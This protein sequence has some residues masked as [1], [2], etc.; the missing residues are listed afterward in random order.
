MRILITGASGFIGGAVARAL[1]E[2]GHD[3]VLAV[4]SPETVRAAFPTAHV[5]ACDFSAWLDPADWTDALAGVDVVI[6][7]VGI[8]QQSG[9]QRFEALH[10]R[11]PVALFRAARDAKVRHVIQISALGADEGAVSCYHRTKKAADDAL[12]AL[13]LDGVILRPSL[14][15]GA[16]AGSAAL[17]RAL[18][19]LPLTPLV[20]EGRQLVQPILIDDL[21]RAV[22]IEV[23]SRAAGCPVIDAVGPEPI[24]FR[25]LLALLCDRFGLGR[26]R[27][28]SVPPA[29]AM[30]LA[31]LAPLFGSGPVTAETVAMLQRG[32]AAAVEPFVMRY[33]F[34]PQRLD[35][36]FAERP[37]SRAERREARLYFAGPALRLGIALLWIWTGLVSLFLFPTSES[38][39]L[40]ERVGL[41]GAAGP[42]ALHA[43]ALL[44][45]GI[46]MAVLTGIKPRAVGLLQ[47][48]VVLAYSGIITVALPEF[49]LHP[50]GPLAKNVPL[51]AAIFVL[52]ALEDGR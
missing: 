15:Y 3:L 8:I 39:D 1:R 4:R 9:L 16:D 37:A 18:A 6:N 42:F 43:A 23:E 38:L 41:T 46:G 24:T 32:N 10:A 31:R 36:V 35:A 48:A 27:A 22:V 49:W 50:F 33:G 21:V 5:V 51:L 29:A 45:V 7:C 17:F 11:A 30:M 25:A 26:L 13:G 19:A 2:R 20:G 34:L 14:V 47:A 28:V 12:L 52:I 44:D 40:L